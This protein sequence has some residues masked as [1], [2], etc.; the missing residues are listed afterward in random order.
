[1]LEAMNS[2]VFYMPLL[3]GPSM[4]IYSRLRSHACGRRKWSSDPDVGGT[5]RGGG[6]KGPVSA[7]GLAKAATVPIQGIRPSTTMT[8][9][10]FDPRPGALPPF[11]NLSLGRRSPAL[12]AAAHAYLQAT[13]APELLAL[14]SETMAVD[15]PG[16]DPELMLTDRQFAQAVLD[17]PITSGSEPAASV[18]WPPCPM[19]R[20]LSPRQQAM[21]GPWVVGSVP[22]GRGVAVMN[23]QVLRSAAFCRPELG[24]P[25]PALSDLRGYEILVDGF[26]LSQDHLDLLLYAISRLRYEPPV[27]QPALVSFT[28]RGFLSALGWSKGADGYERLTKAIDELAAARLTYRDGVRPAT[29]GVV[30]SAALLERVEPSE[31]AKLGQCTLALSSSLCGMLR[32]GRNTVVALEARAAIRGEFGR[33]LHGFVS[34]QKPGEPRRYD[35]EAVCAAGGL[36]AS[37]LTDRLKTLRRTLQDLEAGTSNR[38]AQRTTAEAATC[39]AP[40]PAPALRCF[41]PV[42]MPGWRVTKEGGG[43]LLEMVRAA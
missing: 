34:S 21:R 6:L 9:Y 10:L 20:A 42:V 33:W 8:R 11:P 27:D 15:R 29:N 23:S 3:R 16:G 39:S 43:W 30:Q 36:M 35:A 22:I 31:S 26:S 14:D 12:L 40:A 28:R 7:L 32:F 5:S 4:A 37:R 17:E 38:S 41:A 1:M 18:A 19:P 13:T 2:V 25:N 24:V